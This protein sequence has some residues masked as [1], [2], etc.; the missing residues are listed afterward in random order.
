MSLFDVVPHAMKELFSRE[1]Y[2][3]LILVDAVERKGRSGD[4]LHVIHVP[5]PCIAKPVVGE[6]NEGRIGHA[7]VWR[8]RGVCSTGGTCCGSPI[9]VF[10]AGAL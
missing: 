2:N 8:V 10:L 3:I 4:E 5:V 7:A 1:R 9:D 6:A